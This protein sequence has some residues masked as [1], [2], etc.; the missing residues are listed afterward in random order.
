MN[1]YTDETHERA[2]VVYSTQVA[3]SVNREPNRISGPLPATASLNSELL[4]TAANPE[5]YRTFS[6]SMVETCGV[7][8]YDLFHPSAS[9]VL[10]RSFGLLQDEK[11]TQF[12]ARALAMRGQ[13]RGFYAEVSCVA[14]RGDDHALRGFVIQ[15][16]PEDEVPGST[17]VAGAP[18]ALLSLLESRILEAMATGASTIQMAA[19]FF[20]SRQG[21]EYHV[22]RMLRRFKAPNRA[23]L[24]SRAYSMGILSPGSWPPRVTHEYVKLA[25]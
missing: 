9:S 8:I 6:R 11:R 1:Q 15:V 17:S 3:A 16:S 23:A 24:V 10:P 13:V 22:G 18:R 14:V 21:V 2:P 7:P 12:V 25:S 19:R 20:L 5:F 4:I